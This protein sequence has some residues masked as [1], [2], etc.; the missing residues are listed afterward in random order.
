MNETSREMAKEE[1]TNELT[2]RY[3][4]A[5]EKSRYHVNREAY[6]IMRYEF[7][8]SQ[9]GMIEVW[10]SRNG[11]TPF[12][13][14]FEDRGPARHVEFSRD[15]IQTLHVP[16][17]GDWIFVDYEPAIL[18]R[19]TVI[20]VEK[21]WSH[22]VPMSE[23]FQTKHVALVELTRDTYKGGVPPNIVQ[24]DKELH[25]RRGWTRQLADQQA[26]AASLETTSQNAG[27]PRAAL[28]NEARGTRW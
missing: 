19:D 4:E 26:H 10:N 15:R 25:E 22:R 6:A 14:Y 18:I 21:F 7:E 13:A 23:R 11:V 12:Y 28:R 1:W 3:R 24:V 20:R 5:L 9:H 16:R 2:R 17:V 8:D 27:D